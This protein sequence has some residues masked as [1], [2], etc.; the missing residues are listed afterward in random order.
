MRQPAFFTPDKIFRD[1][2]AFGK[3]R[4]IAWQF[5][6]SDRFFRLTL[7]KLSI[8]YAVLMDF[9]PKSKFEVRSIK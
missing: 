5:S 8:S 1:G 3:N 4:E 6:F 9:V 2:L 7:V